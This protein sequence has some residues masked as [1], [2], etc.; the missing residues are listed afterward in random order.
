MNRTLLRS[1]NERTYKLMTLSTPIRSSPL[2]WCCVSEWSGRPACVLGTSAFAALRRDKPA[3]HA[4]L[5]GDVSS[6]RASIVK[7]DSGSRPTIL[8]REAACKA[9]LPA[10]K[11]GSVA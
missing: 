6:G 5:A 4:G 2:T 9:S 7:L 8:N 1:P 10:S 11:A 3:W